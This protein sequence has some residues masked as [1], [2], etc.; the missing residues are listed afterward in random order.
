MMV[1]LCILTSLPHIGGWEKDCATAVFNEELLSQSTT[2]LSGVD[3]WLLLPNRTRALHG[4]S[5]RGFAAQVSSIRPPERELAPGPS[6]GNGTA[7][8]T[9]PAQTVDEIS[10]RRRSPDKQISPKT[11]AVPPPRRSFNRNP[12]DSAMGIPTDARTRAP[13]GG[14][15]SPTCAAD[16]GSISA[17]RTLAHC[18]PTTEV[19]VFDLHRTRHH[20]AQQWL[21]HAPGRRRG[22]SQHEDAAAASLPH[23]PSRGVTPCCAMARDIGSQRS[24]QCA[25]KGFYS[26][27]SLLETK[28]PWAPP[29]KEKTQRKRAAHSGSNFERNFRKRND[30]RTLTGNGKASETYTSYC[31]SDFVPNA[32]HHERDLF[33]LRT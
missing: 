2:T 20:P 25:E 11:N 22:P 9:T 19:S 4:Y 26:R 10:A 21:E 30:A 12:T 27:K 23:Q 14:A 15:V 29:R 13:A 24:A 1:H 33:G 6:T 17:R 7:T 5:T 31:R 32:T 16:E 18:S 3:S 8:P 28:H